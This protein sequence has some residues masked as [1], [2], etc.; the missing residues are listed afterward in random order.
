MGYF[1]KEHVSME[2]NPNTHS[3]LTELK[4]AVQWERLLMVQFLPRQFLV[5]SCF[6]NSIETWKIFT[7]VRV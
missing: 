7:S 3:S 6:C 5:R 4:T 1:Q 2:F